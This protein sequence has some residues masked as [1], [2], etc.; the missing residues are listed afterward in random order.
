MDAAGRHRHGQR[1]LPGRRRPPRPA[2][3]GARHHRRGRQGRRHL[4]HDQQGRGRRGGQPGHGQPAGAVHRPART[5]PAPDHRRGP[6]DGRDH[7]RRRRRASPRCTSRPAPLSAAGKAAS[8]NNLVAQGV[9]IIA[10]DIFYLDEPMFQD[11]QVAQAVDAAKAAGVNYF[12]SAGNRARQSWEGTLQRRRRQGLRPGRR[13]RHD[14]D[15]R[16][17]HHDLAVHRHSSG[18]S[19]GVPRP[20]TSRST[21]TSTTSGRLQ[22]TTTTSRPASPTSSSR[23]AFSGTHT[24]GDRH[25]PGEPAP[26]RRCMKYIAGGKSPT[27]TIAAVPDQLQRDQP[28]RRVRGRLDGCG[29]QPMVDAHHAGAIQLAGSVDHPA[30]HAAGVPMAPVVRPKPALAAADGVSTTVP[31]AHH[32]LRHQRRD[33]E[34]GGH[35]GADPLGGTQPHRRA[36]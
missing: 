12:A 4:R 27:F 23:S 24:I 13:H 10:D 8:I 19:R 3:A 28:R 22:P 2:G 29:R 17:L 34:R 26:G 16:H 33:A 15:P 14:P 25:P 30:V 18:P 35:R 6:G 21:G 7:L 11:G 36:R 1:A 9:K 20:P 31:G 5:T 32:V